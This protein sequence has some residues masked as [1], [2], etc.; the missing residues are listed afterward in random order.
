MNSVGFIQFKDAPKHINS[1]E[2]SIVYASD[3][4]TDIAT[5]E[6][7]KANDSPF[8]NS[9]FAILGIGLLMLLIMRS[10]FSQ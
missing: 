9:S 3:Q 2:V 6:P 1:D 4:K 10:R 8:S 7:A 5:S